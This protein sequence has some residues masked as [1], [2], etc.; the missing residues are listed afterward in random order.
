MKH[1]F[2]YETYEKNLDAFDTKE[3][4]RKMLIL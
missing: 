2:K 4:E 1:L 3:E